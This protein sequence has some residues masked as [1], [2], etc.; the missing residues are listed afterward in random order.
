MSVNNVLA[1]CIFET[2]AGADINLA[3]VRPLTISEGWKNLS[4]D[5]IVTI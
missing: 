3:D 4:D 2:S 5:G 1:E